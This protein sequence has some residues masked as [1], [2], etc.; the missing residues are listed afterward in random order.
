MAPA[1][2]T[3]ASGADDLREKHVVPLRKED[4]A[5]EWHF[6]GDR[7]AALVQHEAIKGKDFRQRETAAKER[8][9]VA[10]Q[11][12]ERRIEELLKESEAFDAQCNEELRQMREQVH[13]ANERAEQAK[14]NCNAEI[15]MLEE[16]IRREREHATTVEGLIWVEKNNS[17]DMAK[18]IDEIEE[19][20][21][22]QLVVRD[23][24]IERIRVETQEEILKTHRQADQQV[25]EIERK[26]QHELFVIQQQIENNQKQYEGSVS[27]EISKKQHVQTEAQDNVKVLNKE[28]DKKLR[29]TSEKVT[30]MAEDCESHVLEVQHRDFAKEDFL[31]EKIDVMLECFDRAD[32]ETNRAMD[33]EKHHKGRIWETVNVLGTHFPPST[34]YSPILDR[35]MKTALHVLSG[36]D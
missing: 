10:D 3:S 16:E 20:K 26:T 31:K 12:A 6:E 7:H 23:G 5:D 2:E 14:E 11:E 18:R 1:A 34:Q 19:Q 29:G 27:V 21:G 17:R 30:Q 35:K 9:K 25:K 15:L 32:A 33:L 28:I 13:E 22:E 24:Q 4:R 8:K 36:S